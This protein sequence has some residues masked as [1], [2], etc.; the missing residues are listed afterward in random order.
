M[1]V[2]QEMTQHLWKKMVIGIFKKMLSRPEWS[3]GKVDI[4]ESDLV[5]AKYP[6]N[7]CPLKWNLARIIKIHPGEDKVTRVVILKDKNGMHK[8]GQ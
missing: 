5:L 7:Y 1:A 4:K 2:G 6:D 8:K 3:K